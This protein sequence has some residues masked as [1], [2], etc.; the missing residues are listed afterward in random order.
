MHELL[1]V[2]LGP[3]AGVSIA[4]VSLIVWRA[5]RS[6]RPR[7]VFL[8]VVLSALGLAGFYITFVAALAGK[9]SSPVTMWVLLLT[10]AAVS[11]GCGASVLWA[12]ALLR[13]GHS[14]FTARSA[15]PAVAPETS[16][17]A[18]AGPATRGEDSSPSPAERHA[19]SILASKR[20][21]MWLSGLFLLVAM[22]AI[23]AAILYSLSKNIRS[24]YMSALH[25]VNNYNPEKPATLSLAD[26]PWAFGWQVFL[27]GAVAGLCL[28]LT[29]VAAFHVFT[30]F[31]HHPDYPHRRG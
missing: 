18:D 3:F 14:D 13:F 2:V 26:A 4:F 19:E 17:P 8:L 27:L 5:R 23:A 29:Y 15:T 31:K 11:V 16:R 12:T 30:G 7:H 21:G 1:L 20:R 28:Y 25:V 9:L 10:T 6:L 24:G 22:P